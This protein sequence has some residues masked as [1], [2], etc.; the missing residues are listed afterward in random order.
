LK[1]IQREE[2]RSYDN[3]PCPVKELSTETV[4]EG[5]SRFLSVQKGGEC[6]KS[7]NYEEGI[8]REFDSFCKKVLREKAIELKRQLNRRR[9]REATFSDLSP[10]ELAKLATV[11]KYF[12]DEYVFSVLGESVD[13]SNYELGQALNEL[14]DNKRDIVLMSY[15]FDMTDREIAEKLSMERRTVTNRRR[16]SLRK[17]KRIIESEV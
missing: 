1:L 5:I 14:P 16:S 17:L 3:A 13:V 6:M 11:D 9:E 2:A 4:I 12:E 15:F 10:Q 7:Q 8:Q